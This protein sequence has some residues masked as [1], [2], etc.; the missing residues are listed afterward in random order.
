MLSEAGAKEELAESLGCGS[1][2]SSSV[3]ASVAVP[4]VIIVPEVALLFMP[5]R[6]SVLGTAYSDLIP[7][8]SSSE[9]QIVKKAS[10]FNL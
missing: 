7:V 3:L 9:K 2:C 8:S 5:Q 1:V 10:T 6:G 4:D